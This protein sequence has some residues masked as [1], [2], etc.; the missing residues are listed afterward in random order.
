M[1]TRID[2]VTRDEKNVIAKPMSV[3]GVFIS[4]R[5]EFTI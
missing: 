5:D 3:I 2:G 1:G 4:L